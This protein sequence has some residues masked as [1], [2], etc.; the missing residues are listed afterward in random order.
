MA[1]IN[2]QPIQG[3]WPW[4]RRESHH[5]REKVE[6]DLS[7]PGGGQGAAQRLDGY[8]GGNVY[9]QQLCGRCEQLV[10]PV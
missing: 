7:A 8:D 10:L 6:G 3:A 1:M 4:I 2:N 9:G 5:G